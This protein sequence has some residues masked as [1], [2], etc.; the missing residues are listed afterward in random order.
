M[1]NRAILD[2]RPATAEGAA[3]GSYELQ[4]EWADVSG[5]GR[6]WLPRALLMADGVTEG[7]VYEFEDNLVSHTSR[8][9]SISCLHYAAR[10]L[11]RSWSTA[12]KPPK[13]RRLSSTRWHT[14]TCSSARLVPDR[15]RRSECVT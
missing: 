12:P 3:P 9:L 7:M 8:L 4:V 6:I 14:R 5:S 11:A 15:S 2:E 1:A 13:K 10:A